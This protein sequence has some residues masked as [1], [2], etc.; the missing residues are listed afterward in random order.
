M[1]AP[2]LLL[3]GKNFLVVFFLIVQVSRMEDLHFLQFLTSPALSIHIDF[4]LP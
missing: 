2:F 1:L 3:S 4:I